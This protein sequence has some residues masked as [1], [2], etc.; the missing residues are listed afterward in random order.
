MQLSAIVIN[1]KNPILTVHLPET[2]L[3]YF[4][5]P[6]IYPFLINESL[7][8]N[9]AMILPVSILIGWVFYG[10]ITIYRLPEQEHKKYGGLKQNYG[11]SL[12]LLDNILV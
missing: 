5:L 3:L 7:L 2:M 11:F 9:I 1:D 8:F 10:I 6:L 4:K 12:Y